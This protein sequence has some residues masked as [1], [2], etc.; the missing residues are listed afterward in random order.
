M[1]GDQ[2]SISLNHCRRSPSAGCKPQS[3]D[4]D[5]F[6]R[7]DDIAENESFQL[8]MIKLA[9]NQKQE[10]QGFKAHINSSHIMHLLSATAETDPGYELKLPEGRSRPMVQKASENHQWYQATSEK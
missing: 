8:P 2:A 10:T 3:A 5:L 7:I 4:Q 9:V 1:F 6:L